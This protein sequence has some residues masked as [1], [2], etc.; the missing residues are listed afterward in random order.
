MIRNFLKFSKCPPNQNAIEPL[1]F[2]ADVSHTNRI[3]NA[4]QKYSRHKRRQMGCIQDWDQA[5]SKSPDRTLSWRFYTLTKVLARSKAQI[6]LF[7]LKKGI[8]KG[9]LPTHKSYSV[10]KESLILEWRIVIYRWCCKSRGCC[11]FKASKRKARLQRIAC[12]PPRRRCSIPPK[13]DLRHRL[14]CRVGSKLKANTK[15]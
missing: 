11:R 10:F 7:L 13:A 8:K 2:I 9:Y 12:R 15:G 5:R 1:S 14:S 6:S 3:S 4:S